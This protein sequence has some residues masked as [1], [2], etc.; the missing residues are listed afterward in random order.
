MDKNIIIRFRRGRGLKIVR[1]GLKQR[2]IA[3][4]TQIFRPDDGLPASCKNDRL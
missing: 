4:F 3:Q 2:C 1:W